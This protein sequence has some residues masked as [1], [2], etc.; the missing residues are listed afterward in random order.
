MLLSGGSRAGLTHL[1]SRSQSGKS[2]EQQQQQQQRRDREEND[3]LFN[4]ED[5]TPTATT[6]GHQI[7]GH[8]PIPSPVIA[9]S[10]HQ[11]QSL[12]NVSSEMRGDGPS[13]QDRRHGGGGLQESASPQTQMHFRIPANTS[14][15]SNGQSAPPPPLTKSHS[16]GLNSSTTHRSNGSH[17]SKNKEVAVASQDEL[18]SSSGREGSFRAVYPY[19]DNKDVIVWKSKNPKTAVTTTIS[20]LDTRANTDSQ[21]IMSQT[22]RMMDQKIRQ[23]QM[24]IQRDMSSGHLSGSTSKK[25]SQHDGG[26]SVRRSHHGK[27]VGS[28][29]SSQRNS[30]GAHLSFRESTSPTTSPTHR[31][32]DTFSSAAN[33]SNRSKGSSSKGSSSRSQ[34]HRILSGSIFI[35][36][37]RGIAPTPSPDASLDMSRNLSKDG[38]SSKSGV[39][40]SKEQHSKEVSDR[41]RQYETQLDERIQTVQENNRRLMELK[42]LLEGQDGALVLHGQDDFYDDDA[43]DEEEEAWLEER[44]QWEEAKI[45][46][47]QSQN[48]QRRMKEDLEREQATNKEKDSRIEEMSGQLK[49]LLELGDATT[50][51]LRQVRQKALDDREIWDRQLAEERD[52]HEKL[53]STMT[54]SL[55]SKE[56][57][58]LEEAA[59]QRTANQAEIR[60]LNADV[61]SLNRHI[62][63]LEDQMR[64]QEEKS[65][66]ALSKQ[67]SQAKEYQTQVQKLERQLEQEQERQAEEQETR[68]RVRVKVNELAQS[69]EQKE[70]EIQDLRGMLE[71]R[72]ELLDRRQGELDDAHML[73]QSLEDQLQEQQ[74]VA[75]EDHLREQEQH[76]KEVRQYKTELR[77]MKLKQAGEKESTR[78][79]ESRI[80][81]LLE[82]H[83]EASQ[84]NETKIQQLEQE[85]DKRMLQLSQSSSTSSSATNTIHQLQIKNQDQETTLLEKDDRI[86]ELEQELKLAQQQAQSIVADLEQDVH[87]LESDRAKLENLLQQ[88][89][90]Q[91]DEEQ[92][93]AI[94]LNKQ[95]GDKDQEWNHELN[96]RHEQERLLLERLLTDIET[97]Q[98]SEDMD[99]RVNSRFDNDTDNSSID[100]SVNYFYS[101]LQEKIRELKQE[102][103]YQDRA[104]AEL[105]QQLS[106]CDAEIDA[107]Q[108]QLTRMENGRKTL[109]DQVGHLQE[110]LA[111]AEDKE[112]QLRQQLQKRDSQL[113]EDTRE[114]RRISN[115]SVSRRTRDELQQRRLSQEQDAEA[116]QALQ[117]QTRAL[118][119]QI[120]T[121]EQEKQQLLDQLVL[122]QDQIQTMDETIQDQSEAAKSISA[123]YTDRIEALQHEVVKHR[124]MVVKQE[125]QMFLYLSVIEKLKLQIRGTKVE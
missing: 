113:R 93:K 105:R 103:L 70:D 31:D 52:M 18:E 9:T 8:G 51:E 117:S 34:L 81:I 77:E 53:Q 20:M 98:V 99:E 94:E 119:D 10:S 111:T 88:A 3:S 107:Q 15:V 56:K 75:Q 24:D 40:V 36:N 74:A 114:G 30:S 17:R 23:R 5:A 95:L 106:Q 28:R 35:S 102:R 109:E 82:S 96:Q 60:K 125:G 80:Q 86:Q 14:L 38:Q 55:S 42:L 50:V 47:E 122:T 19:P 39:M 108:D 22:R 100:G 115:G 37:P 63:E 2:T 87:E 123:K 116:L 76:N 121:L 64:R 32:Y 72:D 43:I 67:V 69:V 44:A 110:D 83:Q 124:K 1:L 61:S 97:M 91:A 4:P 25:G 104:L 41:V 85:L 57:E 65:R 73:V 26:D 71:E 49:E 6:F 21:S 29:K 59:R 16:S 118:E 46:L 68:N 45:L 90:Q 84:M 92:M 54:A 13:G 62:Q 33:R 48:L 120:S 79:L 66:V 7:N 58:L 101:R 27:E 78:Q 112:Q 12:A 89:H 11:Y